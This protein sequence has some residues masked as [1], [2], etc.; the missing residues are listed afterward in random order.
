MMSF[1]GPA[2]STKMKSLG[3]KLTA[4]VCHLPLDQRLNKAEELT[5]LSTNIDAYAVSLSLKLM[6][7]AESF[8]ILLLFGYSLVLNLANSG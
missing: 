5:Y 1:R 7:S 2:S 6:F 8:K 3:G 4:L